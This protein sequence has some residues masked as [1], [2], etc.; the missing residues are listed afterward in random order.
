MFYPDIMKFL[1]WIAS[2]SVRLTA[3]VVGVLALLLIAGLS[4]VPGEIRPHTAAPKQYEHFVAYFG[5]A[6]I[7][8]FGFGK[9]RFPLIVALF[10]S[11][12][13]AI[14]EMAQIGIPGRD[15]NFYDFV[16]SSAG[17]VGGCFLA[18]VVM[19]ARRRL[20]R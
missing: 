5:A 3:R 16:V 12:Y 6:I 4:L 13:A 18:W 14:L 1:K 11:A 10:L 15:G 9:S 7:L 8:T 20:F 17:A 2:P 19:S